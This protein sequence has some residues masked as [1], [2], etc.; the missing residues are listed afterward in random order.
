MKF[1][2]NPADLWDFAA[3]LYCVVLI[4]GWWQAL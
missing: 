1:R 4:V 2:I 3:A